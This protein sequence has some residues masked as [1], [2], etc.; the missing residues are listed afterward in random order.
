MA[1]VTLPHCNST[2]CGFSENIA[3]K[4][5]MRCDVLCVALR[6]DPVWS[7]SLMRAELCAGQLDAQQ[8][9]L[10]GPRWYAAWTAHGSHCLTMSWSSHRSL[11]E[12]FVSQCDHQTKNCLVGR[13]KESGRFRAWHVHCFVCRPYAQRQKVLYFTPKC[14]TMVGLETTSVGY[15][16]SKNFGVESSWAQ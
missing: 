13:F 7:V 15:R 6:W 3:A 14:I 10:F 2:R 1:V 12:A 11:T 16:H 4:V 8:R 5:L 9:L